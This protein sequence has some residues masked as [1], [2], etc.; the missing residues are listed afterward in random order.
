MRLSLVS[1]IFLLAT[2]L[3]PTAHAGGVWVRA[4]QI[5]YLPNDPKVAI[6]SSDQPL[7]GTFSV[8]DFSADIGLDQGA[9]GPFAHNYRLD[10][11]AYKTPGTYRVVFK[12]VE[13]LPFGIGKDVYDDVPGKLIEFMQLQRCGENPVTGKLCHQQDGID[14]ITGEPVD[15]RGGWHDAGDRL[16]H[17]ITTTYC[18]AALYLAGHEDEADWGADLIRRIHPNPGTIYVQ[19]GDDRD[20][21][22]PKY[23]L[24]RRSIRL[25]PRPRRPALGLARN[26]QTGRPQ[27]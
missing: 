23:P 16:K 10:F 26:R 7:K 14:T 15:L 19:I 21:L 1:L 20:H 17:M 4:N 2:S 6:L 8:G 3:T 27:T 9:W 13:S 22:P 12:D 11:S 18:V 25:R 5:G 24:A